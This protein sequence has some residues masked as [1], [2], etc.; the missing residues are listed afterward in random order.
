MFNVKHGLTSA[1]DQLPPR[2]FKAIAA[3]PKV[4]KVVDRKA[5]EEA[6]AGYYQM[7]GWDSEGVPTREKLEEL[8]LPEFI[9]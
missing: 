7:M 6:I 8:G 4:D 9:N 5:F 2:M 1:D 3:G